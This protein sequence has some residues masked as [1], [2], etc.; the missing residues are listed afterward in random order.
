MDDKKG[1]LTKEE[2][3]GLHFGFGY[4]PY[5]RYYKYRILLEDLDKINDL[6]SEIKVE[7]RD[8]LSL[9]LE[10]ELVMNAVQ[11]CSDL[12]ILFIAS[13]KPPS[14]Y[15]K[16]VASIHDT[17]SGSVSEFYEKISKQP[18]D[19][20]WNLVGYNRIDLTNKEI[21]RGERSI[22]RFKKDIQ[23]ISEFFRDHYQLY[24]G[25]KHGMRNFVLR[26]EYN[27][28]NCI[29]IPTRK[30]DFDILEVGAMWYLKSIEIVEMVHRM[31]TKI[32][33]PLIS[34]ITLAQMTDTDFQKEKVGTITMGKP[35][36]SQRPDRLKIKATLPWKIHNAE[37]RIP[38]Y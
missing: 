11:Y 3:T 16:T 9:M 7:Q 17:G 29:F 12:A 38:L 25:Y 32:I 37:R 28:K 27:G 8:D 1:K 30:G 22:E 23:V 18:D 10:M 2:I 15:I 21:K 34:W 4:N 36:D 33:E 6:F 26:N 19:Y 13:M 35:P 20:F 5:Y 31:F 14:E 24:T